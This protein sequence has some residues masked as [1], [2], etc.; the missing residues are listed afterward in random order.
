MQNVNLVD[1]EVDKAAQDR[2]RKA[3]AQYTGLDDEEFDEDR[4]GVKADILGKYD[5]E[6]STGKARSEGFRLGAAAK[7]KAEEE[8][9]D[10]EMISLG[11]APASKVKLNL[12]F[13]SEYSPRRCQ[14]RADCIL[15]RTLKSRTI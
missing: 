3:L 13:A 8:D 12:D 15:Q 9:G 7:P 4:I 14:G 1:D 10:V 11:Q 2:K 6:F 5:E